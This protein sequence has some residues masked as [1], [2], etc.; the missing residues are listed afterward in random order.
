MSTRRN[1][2]FCTIP[3][4]IFLKF[5]VKSLRARP[6]PLDPHWPQLRKLARR[7]VLFRVRHSAALL[8]EP[9]KLVQLRLLDRTV[10]KALPPCP[11]FLMI[12]GKIGMS[13]RPSFS[14]LPLRKISPL[15]ESRRVKSLA[16]LWIAI[17]ISLWKSVL[18]TLESSKTFR[19]KHMG[20]NR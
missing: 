15:R 11:Q 14:Y 8:P 13:R 12:S 19:S 3:D 4:H 1:R 18:S 17:P 16:L 5:R 20:R 7:V 9:S 2:P 10:K 6:T